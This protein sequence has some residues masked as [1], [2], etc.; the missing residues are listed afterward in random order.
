MLVVCD[1]STNGTVRLATEP[2]IVVKTADGFLLLGPTT[3]FV[4]P[5]DQID[6][7]NQID[8]LMVYLDA[9]IK[10]TCDEPLRG[11]TFSYTEINA[12]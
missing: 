4:S 2:A 1:C 8:G 9:T 5:C 10:A 11:Q 12:H 3:G 6:Q 7:V